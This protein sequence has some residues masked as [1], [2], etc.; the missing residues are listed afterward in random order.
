MR[1]TTHRVE[2]VRTTP[3]VTDSPR[4]GEPPHV[5]SLFWKYVPRGTQKE[6]FVTFCLNARHRIELVDV[7]SIGTLNTS[8]VHPREVF[9]CAVWAGSAALIVAHNH[10]S[11]SLEP[12]E[13]DWSVTR[14]LRKAGEIL[15]IQLLDSL[16]VTDRS[17]WSMR[18]D[19]RWDS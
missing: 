5:Q 8:L 1:Y 16:V 19:R 7:V 12:S 14:R 9:R 13:D 4:L 6:H 10:P 3:V 2:L 17:F 15:G 11:G 18:Q